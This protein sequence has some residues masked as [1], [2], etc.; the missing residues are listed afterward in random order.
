ML[1]KPQYIVLGIVILLT[2]V[3]LKLPNRTA[4]QVKLAISSLFLSLHGLSGSA[5][6]VSEKAGNALV[7]RAELVRQLEQFQH[8]NQELKIRDMQAQQNERENARLRHYYNFPTNRWRLKL[9]RVVAFDPAN[10]WRSIRIN[11]GSRD[12]V[13]NN[14]PVLVAEGLVGRVS[15]VGYAQSQVV[16]LG[17]PDCR[18]AVELEETRDHGIIAPS[19]SSPLDNTLVDILYLSRTSPLKAGQR[20]LTSGAGGIFPP[21]IV[22]GQIVD[23]RSI[24]YGLYNQARVKLEVK[25]NTLEEVWV[26]LP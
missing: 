12:G 26:K 14:S 25:M 3:V 22:I 23:Y 18:V 24:D 19:S 1:R 9:A 7:P 2:V 5:R 15:E 11:L 13:T 17:D 4:A 20:V 21:G 10:W 6:Q 16:L 8:E